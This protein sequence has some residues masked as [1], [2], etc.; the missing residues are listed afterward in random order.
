MNKIKRLTAIFLSTTIIMSLCT[1]G[2]YA[3]TEVPEQPEIIHIADGEEF[4]DYFYAVP[5]DQIQAKGEFSLEGLYSYIAI[6]LYQNYLEPQGISLPFPEGRYLQ[7]SNVDLVTMGVYYYMAIN[8]TDEFSYDL[9][10]TYCLY[11]ATDFY[12]EDADVVD[13]IMRSIVTYCDAAGYEEN[14]FE[15]D[16]TIYDVFEL[17]PE[18]ITFS[19]EQLHYFDA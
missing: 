12:E 4:P 1:C 2:I 16:D 10:K 13:I 17:S 7:Y 5:K 11:N 19:D 6:S 3:E 14:Y 8:V 18:K 9:S 15:S